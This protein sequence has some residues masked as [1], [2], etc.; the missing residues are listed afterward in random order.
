MFGQKKKP[1][2]IVKKKK[3]IGD[4]HVI[5]QDFYGGKDPVVYRS[6]IK[7]AQERQ[8]KVKDLVEKKKKFVVEKRDENILPI[9]ESSKIQK[10]KKIQ[11]RKKIQK[12][13]EHAGFPWIFAIVGF[14]VIMIIIS[15]YYYWVDIRVSEE[16]EEFVVE[17]VEPIEIKEIE[18]IIVEEPEDIIPIEDE[19]VDIEIKSRNQKISIPKIFLVN[20][21]DTD[22]DAL[23]DIEEEVFQTDK[24]I[25]D[26][27]S[28]GYFDSQE[29][30]NL[31]NPTGFAPVRIIDSGLVIE[32]INPIFGY[33]LYYPKV[34][35]LGEVDLSGEQVL[36]SSIT[37]EYIE[38]LAFKKEISQSFEEWFGENTENEKYSDLRLFTNKFELGGLKRDDGM[39]AYFTTPSQVFVIIYRTGIVEEISYRQVFEMLVES[40]RTKTV[41]V[42][43]LPEQ[44]E[45]PKVSVVVTTTSEVL[46]VTTSQE[47][48]E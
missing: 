21:I 32:Y 31:Y 37:G 3:N 13:K 15:F 2:K 47:I 38:V 39:V 25:Y 45:I 19:Q 5:P 40:F 35:E 17:I 20:S 6:N 41:L 8:V 16:K 11:K 14:I 4:I 48:V 1:K 23:T 30:R 18:S 27:D 34:W 46:T 7:G 10:P 44:I 12:P 28:D 24:N 33:K 43:E 36:L 9:K 42:E 26:T 22:K 29:I